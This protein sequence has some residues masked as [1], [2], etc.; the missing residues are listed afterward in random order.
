M[1]DGR[2][3]FSA[4]VSNVGNGPRLLY[5]IPNFF[6]SV[7]HNFKN[8]LTLNRR[9]ANAYKSQYPVLCNFT[10]PIRP[11]LR[12]AVGI[13]YSFKASRTARHIRTSH[14]ILIKRDRRAN[15][16][17][18]IFERMETVPKGRFVNIRRHKNRERGK[19]RRP[20]A[21]K[22]LRSRQRSNVRAVQ[23]AF[24]SAEKSGG[25][26]PNRINAPV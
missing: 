11:T 10:E 6:E 15:M 25:Q 2:Q 20:T 21:P 18:R 26:C 23:P 22:Q 13:A 5:S 16:M 12:F 9:T 1:L 17:R 8:F 24:R 7:K 14:S 4:I 3:S 19:V